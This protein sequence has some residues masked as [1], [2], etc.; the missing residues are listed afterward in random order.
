MQEDGGVL[1]AGEEE[2]GFLEFGHHLTDDVDRL[3]FEGIE[4]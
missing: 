4:M 1:A 3:G 2:G